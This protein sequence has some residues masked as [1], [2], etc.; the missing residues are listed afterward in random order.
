MNKAH[1]HILKTG[2]TIEFKD[3]G[4][5]K[6]NQQLMKLDTSI[7]NYLKNILNTS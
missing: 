1:I 2:G 7:D 6:M 3:P 4:Y 5:E